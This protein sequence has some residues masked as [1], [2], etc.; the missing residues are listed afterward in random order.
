MPKIDPSILLNAF[1]LPPEEAIAFFKSKGYA[2][3]WDWQ[4]LWEEAQSKAFTVAKVAK[5]DILQDIREMT[6]K[7][8]DALPPQ[9]V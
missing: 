3:S 6:Q 9:N 1:N 4:D 5:M 8:L 7:A 2:F